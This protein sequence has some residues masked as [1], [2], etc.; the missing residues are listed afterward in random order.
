MDAAQVQAI[1]LD[2]PQVANWPA[3]AN[4][5]AQ[6]MTHPRQDWELPLLALRAV[7]GDE[8]VV[9]PAAAALIGV[10]LSITLV[11]D[12]LDDDPRGAHLRLGAGATAN[13]AQALQALA[14]SLIQDLPVDAGRR[15]AITASL[16]RMAFATAFGQSLDVQNLAG[17]ENYWRVVR[18]KSTPFY[19]A[20]LEIGALL[21]NATPEVAAR[22]YDFG[23]LNGEI[24]QVYDDLTDALQKPA[25]PDWKRTN[26]NLA[27]LYALTAQHLERPR[28]LE[29]L[30]QI[31]QPEAL[32]RAQQI[33]IRSGAVSYCAYHVIRRYQAAQQILAATPLADPTPLRVMLTRQLEPVLTLLRG[34]GATIPPELDTLIG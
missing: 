7:G 29:L 6:A 33:L 2:L 26:N 28:F 25:N 19:G 3:L 30:S 17:E 9:L 16:A 11:D 4:I 23:A 12:I 22:V 21:G 14:F 10:Q 13:I 18:A 34:V 8:S 1:V 20:G 24:I 5:F 27:L 15:A 32:A 31:D